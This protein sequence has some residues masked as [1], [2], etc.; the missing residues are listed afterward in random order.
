MQEKWGFLDTGHLDAATNMA[1]DEKLLH[2][3]RMGEIPPTLRFYGW[4]SPTLSVGYF[5][6]T[7]NTIDFQ[8]LERHQ[9]QFVRRITGGSAVLHDDELTYSIVISEDHPW[10]PKSVRK[11]YYILSKG[12]IEGYHQLGIYPEYAIPEKVR[13]KKGTAVCFEEPAYYEMVVDGKKISGNAQVRKEGVLL[14]HG[15]IPMSMDEDMLF[16][17]FVYPSERVR[18]RQQAAFK[19]KAITINQ[20]TNKKHSFEELK[21]AFFAG[22]QIGLNISLEPYSLSPTQWQEVEQLAKAK[23]VHIFRARKSDFFGDGMIAGAE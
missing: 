16:D 6:K 8:A 15:S 23:Y 11:A 19:K 14:Q 21:H 9:C 7:E 18:Q 5:Q 3:H 20:I 2:W 10:I 12:I 13:D 1:L 4:S 17:L 22:F